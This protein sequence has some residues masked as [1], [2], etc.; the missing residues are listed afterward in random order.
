[1]TTN[2][3]TRLYHLLDALRHESK[4]Q[5]QE[6]R[7]EVQG[8]RADL[9]GRLKALELAEARREGMGMG[10]GSIGR[11]IM[12]VA[13]VAAAVGSVTGVLVGIL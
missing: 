2:D 9:N 5:A 13:A 4:Q 1:M 11:T 8:Y 3:V 12:G 7:D 6:I 10:R